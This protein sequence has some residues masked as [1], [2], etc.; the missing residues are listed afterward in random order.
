M[1]TVNA[2][3]LTPT[4]TLLIQSTTDNYVGL[5]RQSNVVH[6]VCKRTEERRLLKEGGLYFIFG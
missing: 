5:K 4:D 2:H 1:L 3:L 6:F